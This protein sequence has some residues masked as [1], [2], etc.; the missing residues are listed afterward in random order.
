MKQTKI[1]DLPITEPTTIQIKSLSA[2]NIIILVQGESYKI[3]K[4]TAWNNL[5]VGMKLLVHV[6]IYGDGK[7]GKLIQVE[8]SYTFVEPLA[9]PNSMLKMD[10]IQEYIELQKIVAGMVAEYETNN[11][12]KRKIRLNDVNNW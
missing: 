9:I 6:E 3:S 10:S 11:K 12:S 5:S 4:P 8:N 7:F 2:N 1:K